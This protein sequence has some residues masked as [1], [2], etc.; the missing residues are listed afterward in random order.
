MQIREKPAVLQTPEARYR[1]Q[2][3]SETP[4]AKP[5]RHSNQLST[6]AHYKKWPAYSAQCLAEKSTKGPQTH[7]HANADPR[8]PR[9]SEA[10]QAPWDSNQFWQ[11]HSR[12]DCRDAARGPNDEAA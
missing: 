7:S 10:V 4:G 9:R 6:S 3:S 11:S 12:M 1:R 2:H 8:L 5:A